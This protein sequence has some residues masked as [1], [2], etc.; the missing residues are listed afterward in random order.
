M[1]QQSRNCSDIL[2][3]HFIV[4]PRFAESAWDCRSCRRLFLT[5]AAGCFLFVPLW[6]AGG[7]VSLC[8]FWCCKADRFFSFSD[9]LFQSSPAIVFRSPPPLLYTF[10]IFTSFCFFSFTTSFIIHFFNLH[11]LMFI[12][13]LHLFD[14]LLSNIHRLLLL[15]VH[16]LVEEAISSL[17]RQVVHLTPNRTTFKV[18]KLA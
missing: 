5:V 12:F 15:F 14:Y 3:Q 16:H 2:L 13:V 8:H 1:L 10:S 4:K 7:R 17:C 9:S 18:K 11:L 6:S